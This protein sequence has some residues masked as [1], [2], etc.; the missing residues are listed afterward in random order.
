MNLNET[1][2]AP[3]TGNVSAAIAVI[4]ISGEYAI[5]VTQQLFKTSKNLA[6]SPSHT[7]HFGKIM[8]KDEVVDEVLVSLFKNPN[9]YT[10]EDVIEISCHGSLYI[11]QRIMQLFLDKGLRLAQPGEFTM[12]AFKNG[13]LDLAQAEAVADLIASDT[14][15]AHEVAMNQMRGGI[16]KQLTALR[17][18]LINFA[19]LMELELDFSGEDVEFADR[20]QFRTLLKNIKQNIVPLIESFAYGNAIKQGVAVAIVGKPNAGKSSLLNALLKEDRAIVSDIAGTTRDTIEDM[21]VVDGIKFRLT[22]TAG[23]RET[24]DEIEAIGVQRSIAN[25][26]KSKIVLFLYDRADTTADEIKQMLRP[27]FDKNIHLFLIE[28]KIDLN[29]VSTSFLDAEFLESIQEEFKHVENLM[30]SAKNEVSVHELS[31]KLAEY[32]KTWHDPN[33]QVITQTRH[34][35]ALKATLIAVESIENGLNLD[36]PG[37][38]LAQDIREAIRELGSITGEI[39]VDRDILGT[40]FGEFCIG[41]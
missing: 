28:N 25:A 35:N 18:E 29:D 15:A 2:I 36:I 9:S 14:R 40:I 3:A 12:R 27:L 10:G 24:E 19:A 30:V 8:D 32:I 11:Q 23:L 26:L 5:T 17:K 13:K 33:A 21:I 7:L 1:I 31:Q 34:L 38:L 37:D 16:S 20:N 4:R 22:D 6:D 41:K 39:E